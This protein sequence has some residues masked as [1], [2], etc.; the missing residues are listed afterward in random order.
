MERGFKSAQERLVK[1]ALEGNAWQADHVVPVYRGGGLCGLEN[2]RTLC[3]PCHA[4]VTRQQAKDRATARCAPRAAMFLDPLRAECAEFS[5]PKNDKSR[6]CSWLRERV[7]GSF[8]GALWVD[9]A[10]YGCLLLRCAI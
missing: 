5:L 7:G 1:T 2:L 8:S 3:T 4:D 9:S 6:W 10:F